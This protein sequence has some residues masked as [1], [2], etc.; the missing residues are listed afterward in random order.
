ML[1]SNE[2][3]NSL[4][5]RFNSTLKRFDALK[6]IQCYGSLKANIE[7]NPDVLTTQITSSLVEKE[8]GTIVKTVEAKISDELSD[9]LVKK[10]QANADLIDEIKSLIS[11]VG[12]LRYL[13]SLYSS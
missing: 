4:E 12:T 6:G 10:D 8:D 7:T 13:I 3:Y 9:L 11:W 5:T 1:I 2:V